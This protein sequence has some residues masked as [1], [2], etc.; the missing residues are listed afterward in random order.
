MQDI[1]D[2][3]DPVTL[4][5]QF[6]KTVEIRPVRCAL[7]NL[8]TEEL[9]TYESISSL[10]KRPKGWVNVQAVNF[11]KPIYPD[12]TIP[13]N[14]LALLD[15]QWEM[16]GNLGGQFNRINQEDFICNY[17]Y[18]KIRAVQTLRAYGGSDMLQEYINRLHN[19][20]YQFEVT[21]NDESYTN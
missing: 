2:I 18:N 17:L 13:E 12:F 10:Y 5:E 6:C 14:F 16:F 20:N 3:N 8:D 11:Q 9:R 7:I 15:I 19:I 4:N 21:V 1:L